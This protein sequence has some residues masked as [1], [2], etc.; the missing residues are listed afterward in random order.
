MTKKINKVLISGI[1][2]F[3]I[4]YL[5][6]N[7]EILKFSRIL[8]LIAMIPVLLIP[9][10]LRKVF[11]LK[12]EDEIELFYIIFVLFAQ[13][14]GSVFMFYQRYPFYDKLLHF[15]S[16]ILTSTF[17]LVFLKNNKAKGVSLLSKLVVIIIFSV[18]IA[19]FWEMF[20]FLSDKI[21]NSDTQNVLTTGVDDTMYDIIS[22]FIGSVIFSIFY[23]F[24]KKK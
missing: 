16:G 14:F 7:L 9:S 10:I 8:I 2:I 22:A 23:F 19:G 13:L 24:Y 11:K 12:I 15:S 6:L 18:A 17:A 1:S 5:I 3:S 4:I 20:E 21:L